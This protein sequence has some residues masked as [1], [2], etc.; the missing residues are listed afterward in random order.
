M[1]FFSVYTQ[2]LHD[3]LKYLMRKQVG[4]AIGHIIS[5]R[6]PANLDMLHRKTVY[7]KKSLVAWLVERAG[8][9]VKRLPSMLYLE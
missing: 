5:P 3:L 4:E 2:L 6:Y 9:L 8:N 1:Y 7:Y